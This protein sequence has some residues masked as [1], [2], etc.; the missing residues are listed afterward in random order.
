MSVKWNGTSLLKVIVYNEG[1]VAELYHTLAKEAKKGMGEQFFENLA[2]DEEKHEMI[3][4]AL[5]RRLPIIDDVD[6]EEEDAKYMDLLIENNFL[7]N[8][9]EVIEDARKMYGKRQV[10]D[11]AERVER[12]SVLFVTELQRLYPELSPNEMRVILKEEKSHLKKILEKKTEDSFFR[13]GM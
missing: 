4:N 10:F 11:I 6:L 1:K 8:S 7:K 2:A 3:Y 13:I 9:D 5:L 12:D